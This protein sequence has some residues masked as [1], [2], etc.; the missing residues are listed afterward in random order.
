[1]PAQ[2]YA[3]DTPAVTLKDALDYVPGVFIQPKWGEEQPAIDPRLGVIAK[4]S[5]PRVQLFMNGIP[6]NTADGFGDFQE[7]DPSAYSYIE[8]FKG[9]NA[10]RFGANSLGG[11]INFVMP[12]G[13][14]SDL[15]GAR[16]DIGSFGLTKTSVS[17]GA[18]SGNTDYAIT[19]TW[20]EQDGFRDHSDGESFRGSA[21][22]G[23]RISP[24]VK[25]RFFVNANSIEQRIP[26]RSPNRRL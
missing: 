9:A 5:F 16:I 25:S 2:A 10:L 4:F 8:V 17:S 3:K 21:N 11:A 23:F 14:D 24:D 18:V 1:M 20:L 26:E 22:V 13:Y 7:I 12:T 6:I 19:A 15:F